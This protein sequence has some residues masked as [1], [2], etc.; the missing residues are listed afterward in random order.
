MKKKK[1]MSPFIGLLCAW[2]L[3]LSACASGGPNAGQ[4]VQSEQTGKQALSTASGPGSKQ[5]E[6]T[7]AA[8]AGPAQPL[9]ETEQSENLSPDTQA[10][11][12]AS[13]VAG[14]PGPGDNGPVATREVKTGLEATDPE[15]VQLASGK[16]QLVE[17]FAFW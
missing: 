14:Y 11:E 13:T 17:F 3:L 4:S 15:K 8:P 1:R 5:G 9:Q 2:A 12:T 16:P 10:S 6:P 7:P